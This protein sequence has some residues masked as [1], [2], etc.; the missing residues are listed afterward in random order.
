M[1]SRFVCSNQIA[2]KNTVRHHVEQYSKLDSAINL[3][4]LLRFEQGILNATPAIQPNLNLRVDNHTA[5][6]WAMVVTLHVIQ[7]SAGN[8]SNQVTSKIGSIYLPI[9]RVPTTGGNN[10]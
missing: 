4:A 5:Q 6:N 7:S 9:P 10:F 8:V 3:S 1:F 2:G